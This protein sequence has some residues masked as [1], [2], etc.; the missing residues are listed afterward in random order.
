MKIATLLTLLG[1]AAQL[2]PS[3]QA[4]NP[5]GAALP[6]GVVLSEFIA[7]PPPT[8]SVHAS[9]IVEAD[10]SLLAA[11]FGG[12]EEGARDVVIWLSR[13]DGNGW[14]KPEE[15][16]NG[17][18]EKQRIQYPCWNPV[19]YRLNTGQ[20]LLFY[21]EGPSPARW[22]SLMKV[23]DDNGRTWSKAQKLPS[24]MLGPIKNKPVEV[25]E[26]LLC[27]SSVEND[28]WR[29]YIERSRRPLVDQ[30]WSKSMPL[31]RSIDY[32]AIQPTI[33]AWPDGNVQVLCRTRQDV[34]T[35]SWSGDKGATWS[36]MRPTEL[37]NPNS[38]ID[39]VMMHDGRAMLV[40]NHAT[41]GRGNLNVAISPDGRRWLAATILENTPGSEFSYPA[42]IQTADKMIHVTYT[43]NREKIKHMVIDP[44][45]LSTREMANGEWPK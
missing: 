38:G 19:L 18:Y 30:S 20:V 6:Q 3:S 35:E 21:R 40:Y 37:P 15:V 45:Q 42:V 32:G 10:K 16:A 28:G 22:W 17:V 26:W 33:L 11:W 39:A 2:A 27:G 41:S 23:S 24:G 44:A 8:P 34:I 9:T 29:V 25:G 36:R 43:W 31:N 14:S 12:S 13:N 1:M 7:D 5:A 4:Q